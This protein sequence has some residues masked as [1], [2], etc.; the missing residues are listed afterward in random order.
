MAYRQKVRVRSL[1]LL[2]ELRAAKRYSYR[3]MEERLPINKTYIGYIFS[4]QVTEIAEDLG[5]LI[6]E[7]LGIDPKVLFAPT[8]SRSSGLAST[9]SDAIAQPVPA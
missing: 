9:H 6:A 3:D 7:V 5:D 4:G 8:V 1:P 2:Q